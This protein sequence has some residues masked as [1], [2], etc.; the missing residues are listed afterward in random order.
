MLPK[1]IDEY[2]MCKIKLSLVTA[3]CGNGAGILKQDVQTFMMQAD[4]EG[5]KCQPMILFNEWIRRFEK[6]A[7]TT[8]CR[9]A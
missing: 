2:V 4:R 3:K 8:S 6:I 5:S 9:A 7:Q 1:F